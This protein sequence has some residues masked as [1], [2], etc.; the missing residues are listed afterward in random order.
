MWKCLGRFQNSTSTVHDLF[1]LVFSSAEGVEEEK[2]PKG[3]MQIAVIPAA[4]EA[5]RRFGL[6]VVSFTCIHLHTLLSRNA[7]VKSHE[8]SADVQY[9]DTWR[10]Y[11]WDSLLLE[12]EQPSASSQG[13]CPK[14]FSGNL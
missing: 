6:W 13:F 9:M 10:V 12:A 1:D 11:V 7:C 4:Q 14:R 5:S 2:Y 3:R 8:S